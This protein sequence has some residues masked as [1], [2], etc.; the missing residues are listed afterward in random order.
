GPHSSPASS[1]PCAGG[2]W[3]RAGKSLH[4]VIAVGDQ[5][6]AVAIHRDAAHREVEQPLGSTDA[7][8]LVEKDAGLREYLDAVIATVDHKDGARRTDGD[9]SWSGELPVPP[10]RAAPFAEKGAGAG[11]FLNAVVEVVRD[12]HVL[13]LIDGNAKG[14]FELPVGGALGAPRGEESPGARELLHPVVV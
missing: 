8:P 1:V 9:A 6:G 7:A 3:R 2:K 10:S 13:V 4:P 5:H 14:A 11:K 12:V